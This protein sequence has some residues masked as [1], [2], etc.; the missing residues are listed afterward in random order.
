MTTNTEQF[1][2]EL[3][4]RQIEDEQIIQGVANKI[5]EVFTDE[6]QA[7]IM[8]DFYIQLYKVSRDMDDLNHNAIYH[9]SYID[10]FYALLVGE[11]KL[12]NKEQYDAEVKSAYQKSLE[13]IKKIEEELSKS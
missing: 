12:L 13:V 2:Q 7:S 8:I 9:T 5:S 11:D 3:E 4:K 6:K 1:K 10:A